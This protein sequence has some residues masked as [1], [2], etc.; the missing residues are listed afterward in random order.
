MATW[1]DTCYHNPVARII[2]T[3]FIKRRCRFGNQRRC[4]YECSGVAVIV[5][6][7]V[8]AIVASGVAAV[9][10][11]GVAAV[12]AAAPPP[13]APPFRYQRRHRFATSGAAASL[14]AAPPLRPAALPLRQR[15][16]IRLAIRSCHRR[17]CEPC[18]QKLESPQRVLSCNARVSRRGLV[19]S[20]G[21]DAG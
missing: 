4:R 5:A 14:P 19:T 8:A 11:S 13:A 20:G 12:V 7:G 21:G 1:A 3:L 9:V 17:I 10:A 15:L 18:G 16:T 2:T 6:S